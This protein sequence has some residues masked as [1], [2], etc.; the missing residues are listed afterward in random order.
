MSIKSIYLAGSVPKSDKEIAEVKDWRDEYIDVLQKID[1]GFEFLNPR[2]DRADEDDPEGVFGADCMLVRDA[3]LIIVDA[4][5]KIG[6]GTAQEMLIAKYFKR[7]VIMV[8]PKE[9]HHRRKDMIYDGKV[10]RDWIHPFL[11]ET[12]D[13]IVESVDELGSALEKL[14]EIENKDITCIDTAIEYY[15]KKYKSHSLSS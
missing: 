12:S 15:Q 7:P 14:K 5:K 10:I 3:D 4:P 11:H 8:L 9:T 13:V 6:A 1:N 2:E